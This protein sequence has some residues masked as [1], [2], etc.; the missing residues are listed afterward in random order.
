MG[1]RPPPSLILSCVSVTVR[2]TS[3]CTTPDLTDSSSISGLHYEGMFRNTH[4]FIYDIYPLPVVFLQHFPGNI[5]TRNSSVSFGSFV[6]VTSYTGISYKPPEF[7]ALA[8]A[9]RFGRNPTT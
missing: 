2:F 3:H 9:E 4:V 8:A 5:S 7:H 1:L 6:H